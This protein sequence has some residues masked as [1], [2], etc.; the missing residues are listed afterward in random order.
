M[1]P[2]EIILAII[3]IV[4]AVVFFYLSAKTD[5]DIVKLTDNQAIRAERE[6]EEYRNNLLDKAFKQNN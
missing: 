2:N 4:L 5:P 6:V 1:T 3:A